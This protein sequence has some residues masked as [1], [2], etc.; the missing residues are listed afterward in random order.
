MRTFRSVSAVPSPAPVAVPEIG[1]SVES[2]P[3]TAS[4][5]VVGVCS[6][7]ATSENDTRPTRSSPGTFPR[8][9]S[10]A[11]RAASR[12][13]GLTSV[14]DIE[15]E[16]SVTS[17]TDARSTA[18]WTVR[19]GRAS[20]IASAATASASSA[21]GRCRLQRGSGAATDASVASAGKRTG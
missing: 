6:V 11:W 12:R 3:E 20:E 21:N 10:A 19:S 13:V 18:T 15:R 1:C 14:A 17:T 8:K 4:R 16:T 5:S 2:A 7:C 9:F